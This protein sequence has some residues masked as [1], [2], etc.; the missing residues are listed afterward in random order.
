M[1]R[2]QEFGTAIGNGVAIPHLRLDLLTS[3]VLAFGRS[4]RGVNWNEMVE[5]FTTFSSWQLHRALL[6]FMCGFLLP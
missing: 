6:T 3:P 2:E 4:L 1:A 5:P